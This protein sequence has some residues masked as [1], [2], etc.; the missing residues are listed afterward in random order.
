MCFSSPQE[1]NQL[2]AGSVNPNTK[3]LVTLLGTHIPR[4]SGPFLGQKQMLVLSGTQLCMYRKKGEHAA[5]EM[6]STS[7]QT[8]PNSRQHVCSNSSACTRVPLELFP[9]KMSLCP[10]ALSQLPV[11]LAA[12]TC[13]MVPLPCTC[14]FSQQRWL[15]SINSAEAGEDETHQSPALFD[16]SLPTI[17]FTRGRELPQV[18]SSQAAH[19]CWLPTVEFC[20]QT[21]TPGTGPLPPH[22]NLFTSQ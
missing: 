1:P 13:G 12:S 11:Q 8:V 17:T 15:G 4:N 2:C 22:S 3:G 18:P 14:G 7:P 6:L 5:W 19:C 16:A 20:T 9:S 10:S 21:G